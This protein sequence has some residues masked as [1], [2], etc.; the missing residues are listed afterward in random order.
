MNDT[1]KLLAVEAIKQLKSRY[2]YHLDNKNWA[3]WRKEV[4]ADDATLEVPE[5][6]DKPV[7]G[8]DNIVAW[9]ASR[10][11]GV[12][13]THHGHMPDIEITS[14]DSATG[15][16]AMEDILRWPEDSP[17]PSGHTF[18]HGFGHYR[19]AYVKTPK[20]WRIQSTRLTRLHVERR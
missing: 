14:G 6:S 4:W 2:F 17:G 10:F 9:T 16:W 19:E 13:A 12:T 8:A 3:A 7:T 5:L 15:I 1:E 18:I 20:G 11:K